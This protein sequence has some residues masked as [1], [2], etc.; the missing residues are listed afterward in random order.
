MYNKDLEDCTQLRVVALSADVLFGLAFACT[1]LATGFPVP[2]WEI[3]DRDPQYKK[4]EDARIYTV[5]F[6]EK[7]SVDG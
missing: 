2:P 5:N 4:G 7:T 1:R 6:E 3:S